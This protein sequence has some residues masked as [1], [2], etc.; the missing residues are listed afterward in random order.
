[1]GPS[2]LTLGSKVPYEYFMTAGKGESDAGSKGLPFE[3]G[4]YD[5][6]LNDAGIEDANIV[7]YTS[8]IPTGAK[9]I[10]KEDGLK[11]IAWGEKLEA[12]MAQANGSK[13]ETITAGV[14]TSKVFGK[15]GQYLGGFAV[16][17]SGPG[18]KEQVEQ[19]LLISIRGI[20]ERRGY[21]RLPENAKL[22]HDNKTD[23]GYTIHPGFKFVYA[24][25]DPITKAHGTALAAICFVSFKVPLLTSGSAVQSPKHSRTR[26]RTR[27]AKRRKTTRRR[28]R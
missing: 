28:S 7:K 10:S 27:S 17:Y 19:A 18:N 20:I 21:G 5:A 9:F 23:L 11:T 15:N 1:M 8:V 2:Y 13:G 14:M 22:R 3:T 24:T 6:A 16:E 12:I 25:M 26:S 4:S